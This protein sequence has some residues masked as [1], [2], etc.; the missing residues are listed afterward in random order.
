MLFIQFFCEVCTQRF[1]FFNQQFLLA[2][3]NLSIYLRSRCSYC[4]F[5]FCCCKEWY[6]SIRSKINFLP[7]Y[8]GFARE[9]VHCTTFRQRLKRYCAMLLT[10]DAIFSILRNKYQT[11]FDSPNILHNNIDRLGTALDTG[12]RRKTCA[13][14]AGR[15]TFR[16]LTSS[17]QSGIQV[18]INTISSKTS[19]QQVH[20]RR[21]HIHIRWPQ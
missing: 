16:I 2:P 12:K 15:M 10:D 5:L 3:R 17:Q 6:T 18:K 20:L 7:S 21:P 9:D 4:S 1:K 19:L 14:V 8:F 13:E 11:I